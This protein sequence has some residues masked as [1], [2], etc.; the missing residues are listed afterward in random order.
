MPPP[1]PNDKG[2][3]TAVGVALIWLFALGPLIGFG[4][5]LATSNAVLTVA[6]WFGGFVLALLVALAK[7]K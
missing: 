6:V 4:L 2:L 5:F 3:S 7:R 1:D